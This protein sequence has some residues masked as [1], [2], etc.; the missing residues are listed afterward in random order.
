MGGGGLRRQGLPKLQIH[1]KH[2]HLD[3]QFNYKDNLNKL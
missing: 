2:T 1:H 3:T